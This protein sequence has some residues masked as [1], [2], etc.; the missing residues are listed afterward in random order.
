MEGGPPRSA[1]QRGF[2]RS[3]QEK[4]VARIARDTAELCH[5][6]VAANTR[7]RILPWA[8]DCISHLL[9]QCASGPKPRCILIIMIPYNFP[10]ISSQEPPALTVGQPRQ[11]RKPRRPCRLGEGQPRRPGPNETTRTE[12]VLQGSGP[13]PAESS[14]KCLRWR[15]EALRELK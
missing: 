5:G 9:L 8:S 11:Q 7:I 2:V 1:T 15:R 14:L 13:D 4:R 10:S 12:R 3:A 6:S